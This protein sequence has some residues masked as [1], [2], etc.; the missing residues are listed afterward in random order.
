MVAFSINIYNYSVICLCFLILYSIMLQSMMGLV[1][2]SAVCGNR[3]MKTSVGGL[4]FMQ[5]S[6]YVRND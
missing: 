6:Y 2:F 1:W 4:V 5:S 3:A